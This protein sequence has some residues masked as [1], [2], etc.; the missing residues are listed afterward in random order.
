[1]AAYPKLRS[2]DRKTGE[3]AFEVE[4]KR[5]KA[6]VDAVVEANGKSEFSSKF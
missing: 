3:Y 4:V 1:M 5:G 2:E 6:I